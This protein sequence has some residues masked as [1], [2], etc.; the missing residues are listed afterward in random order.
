MDNT[1]LILRFEN[2]SRLTVALQNS[3]HIGKKQREV[4]EI[5]TEYINSGNFCY[6]CI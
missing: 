3:H 5:L 2:I 1:F 6:Y 4:S